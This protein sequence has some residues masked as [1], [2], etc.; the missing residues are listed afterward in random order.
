VDEKAEQKAAARRTLI[1]IAFFA[2]ILLPLVFI[3]VNVLQGPGV[4]AIH[5]PL[6]LPDRIHVCGRDYHGP[7]SARTLDMIR[8]DGIEPVLV[9]TG[10]LAPCPAGACTTVATVSG[11]ATVVYVRVGDDA[12]VAYELLG[13]P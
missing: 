3:A 12:Y 5:N 7:G 8:M 13:G 6:K 10:V 1:A 2:A 4:M 11:C 9:D